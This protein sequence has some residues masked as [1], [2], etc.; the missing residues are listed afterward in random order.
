VD[1]LRPMGYKAS[2][3]KSTVNELTRSK[4]YTS[5]DELIQDVIRNS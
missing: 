1:A 3:I 2:D 5:V 4:D